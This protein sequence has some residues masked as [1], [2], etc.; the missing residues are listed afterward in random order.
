MPHIQTIDRFQI[1]ESDGHGKACNG[2][3]KTTGIQVREYLTNGYI[4]KKTFNFVIGKAEKKA[5]ALFH[6]REFIKNNLTRT[7]AIHNPRIEPNIE[8]IQAKMIA[9]GGKSPNIHIEPTEGE[10]MIVSCT[11]LNANKAKAYLYKD[12]LISIWETDKL[13]K[14]TL[15]LCDSYH[16][17]DIFE[18]LKSFIDELNSAKDEIDSLDKIH[19]KCRFYLDKQDYGN[20]RKLIRLFIHENTDINILKTILIITRSFKEHERLKE[21]R[22]NIK[23]IFDKKMRGNK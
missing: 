16:Q 20:F 10:R 4:L 17:I 21:A 14:K 12:I 15:E 13:N 23:E 8:F 11:E 2:Q 9:V 5:A 19:N 6:A 3:K 18:D 22:E 1:W 7:K